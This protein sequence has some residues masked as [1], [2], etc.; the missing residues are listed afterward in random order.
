[1]KKELVAALL[2]VLLLAGCSRTPRNG[3]LAF[4]LHLRVSDDGAA[5][6]SLGVHN[7]SA[8]GLPGDETFDGRMEL[9]DGSGDLQAQADV[10]TL[11]SIKPYESAFPTGWEGTLEPG[12]YQLVWGAPGYGAV[13]AEFPAVAGEWTVLHINQGA[14]EN[15]PFNTRE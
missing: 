5:K 3:R 6:I 8:R 2:V 4:E 9:R 13:S 10:G 14:G 7:A 12:A 1:V 11:A 15:G